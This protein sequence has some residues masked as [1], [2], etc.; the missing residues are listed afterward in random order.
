MDDLD[1]RRIYE[2]RKTFITRDGPNLESQ[3]REIRIF[4]HFLREIE[5]IRAKTKDSNLIRMKFEEYFWQINTHKFD[6]FTLKSSNNYTKALCIYIEINALNIL[7]ILARCMLQIISFCVVGCIR[8]F[9]WSG[10]F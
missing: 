2:N 6:N 8:G 7:R 3:I 4:G 10:R 1:F 9:G 5:K